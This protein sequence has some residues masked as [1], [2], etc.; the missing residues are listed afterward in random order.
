MKTIELRG[1]KR[2]LST[3]GDLLKLRESGRVPGV[4]YGEKKEP[5][6]MSVDVKNFTQLL[7]GHGANVLMNLTVGENGEIVLL[8]DVQRDVLSH[9]IIHLDFQRISMKKMIEVNVPLLVMGEAPGVKIGGGVLEHILRNLRVRCLPAD[10][11]DGIS[12]DVSQL[13]LNQ[14][15]KV[16]DVVLPAG[17]ECITEGEG[18]VLNIVAPVEEEVAPTPVAGAVAAGGTEPEV[19]AKGKKPEEGEAVP[20]GKA[21]AAG[22]KAAPAGKEKK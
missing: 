11:P 4:V 16:K 13:Q 3:K 18:L 1:E 21:P 10:I 22:A 19:I 6:T 17:V 9:N 8:K 14:G 5:I 20:G 15:I 12:V 7:K 2:E